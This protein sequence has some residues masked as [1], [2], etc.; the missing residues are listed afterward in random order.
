MNRNWCLPVFF[1]CL[2][3]CTPISAT[4]H[5]N[6]DKRNTT[7]AAHP[8][9]TLPP[10]HNLTQGSIGLRKRQDD[11]S[12]TCGFHDGDPDRP[13]TAEDGFDCR[14]DTERG[15]WGFCPTTVIAASDCGLAGN[16][17]DEHECSRGC[18]IRGTSGVTTFTWFVNCPCQRYAM[19]ANR[20]SSTQRAGSVL[21]HRNISPQ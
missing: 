11:D 7:S 13:R 18:G 2:R 16:C 10:L 6:F 21:L 12:E 1:V 4:P 3:F 19:K 17:V 20:S 15:L 5:G 9:V 14:I 8:I